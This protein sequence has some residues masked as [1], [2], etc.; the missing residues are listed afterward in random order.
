M[1][2]IDAHYNAVVSAISTSPPQLELT[3]YRTVSSLPTG[4]D[5]EQRPMSNAHSADPPS[6]TPE[7]RIDK[8]VQES[9]KSGESTREEE[10]TEPLSLPIDQMTCSHT[11]TM[12]HV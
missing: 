7:S 3:G 1:V 2:F 5:I 6:S 9:K 8:P 10:P 4:V 11:R 12:V